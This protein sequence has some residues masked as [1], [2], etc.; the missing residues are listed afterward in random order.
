[1]WS[2]K[3]FTLLILFYSFCTN[4]GRLIQHLTKSRVNKTVRSSK[5]DY[6]FK[7]QVVTDKWR[8][9]TVKLVGYSPQNHSH[10]QKSSEVKCLGN[11]VF[12]PSVRCTHFSHYKTNVFVCV[13]KRIMAFFF[14]FAGAKNLC[15]SLKSLAYERKN[16]TK[17]AFFCIELRLVG[18]VG[19]TRVIEWDVHQ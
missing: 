12:S 19:A 6:S 5:S 18:W 14:T 8:D 4:V 16:P 2:R 13:C 15:F 17:S 3:T 10:L 9:D 11:S 7:L 1:M